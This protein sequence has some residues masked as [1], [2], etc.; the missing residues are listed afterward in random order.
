MIQ[1]FFLYMKPFS[2]TVSFTYAS[3]LLFL[4]WGYGSAPDET[5]LAK[6]KGTT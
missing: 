6:R 3:Y 2:F 1:Q 5:N 4:I